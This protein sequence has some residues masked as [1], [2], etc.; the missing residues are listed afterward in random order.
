[1]RGARLETRI[2]LILSAETN[3]A[4]GDYASVLTEPTRLASYA[5]IAGSCLS[6]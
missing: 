4:N 1:M 6:M 3:L 2:L 5:A